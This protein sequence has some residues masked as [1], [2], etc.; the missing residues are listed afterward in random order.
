MNN[1]VKTAHQDNEVVVVD[2]LTIEVVVVDVD[3]LMQRKAH[4]LSTT[5]KLPL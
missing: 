5:I 4:H 3:E 2:D 1:N